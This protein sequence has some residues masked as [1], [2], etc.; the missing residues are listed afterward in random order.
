[1]TGLLQR[2]APSVPAALMLVL[3]S[4]ALAQAP[5]DPAVT[6]PAEA[7]FAGGDAAFY[8]LTFRAL[9]VLFVLAILIESALAVIFNWRLFL[10]LFYGR[11][12]K[13]LVMIAVSA[14]VVAAFDI[15][16]VDTLMK[17][18]GVV[19]PAAEQS[20]IAFWL[21]ALILAGGSAGVYRILVALGYRKPVTPEQVAPRPPKDRAWIA[22]RTERKAAVGPIEIHVKD[23][24]EATDASPLPLAGM[25]G[26]EGFWR[27]VAGVFVL[28]RTRFPPAGGYEVRTGREY[29]I[30]VTGKDAAGAKLAADIDGV[31][32]FAGGAIIDFTATL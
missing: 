18:Y 8:R 17:G 21:T 32:T 31:Y 16:V 7:W 1:M 15:N 11:G 26:T 2:L 22:V 25:I 6:V 3:A 9:V 12:V 23:L 30:A 5:A 14:L 27:R 19:P 28:D 24:G 13:T 4:A 10:Q 20:P 29:R